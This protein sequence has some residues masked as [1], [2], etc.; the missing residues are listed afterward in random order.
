MLLSQVL[1][2]GLELRNSRSAAVGSSRV[3]DMVIWRHASNQQ[4]YQLG[5]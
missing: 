1:G 5:F 4:S 2:E 3:V